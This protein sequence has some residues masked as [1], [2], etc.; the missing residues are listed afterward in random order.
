MITL[1][2]NLCTRCGKERIDSKT[3][4][5]EITSFFGATTITHTE[6][7]CPDPEC[8][9]IVEEK[10]DALRQK[11]EDMKV[12]KEKRK[13]LQNPHAAANAL[14]KAED[15]RKKLAEKKIAVAEA[16]KKKESK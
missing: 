15:N 7:V 5:E 4:E 12:E 11:T 3:W 8:Q 9:K 13:T 1:S 14:K 16:K 6:T 10:M 2:P